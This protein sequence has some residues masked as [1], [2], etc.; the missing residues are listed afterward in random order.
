MDRRRFVVSG[1]AA[2]LVAVG[3]PSVGEGATVSE[4]ARL[5]R[6]LRKAKSDL[7]KASDW[8]AWGHEA[9]LAVGAKEAPPPSPAS[10]A[11]FYQ[12]LLDQRAS[13]ENVAL[14]DFSENLPATAPV[15]TASLDSVRRDIRQRV[16]IVQTCVT[17]VQE[18][19]TT[20]DY[21]D[22]IL[23]ALEDQKER[24][25]QLGELVEGLYT[26]LN[27]HTPGF[28]TGLIQQFLFFKIFDLENSYIPT[29]AETA[30]I[31]KARR[32]KASAHINSRISM[33]LGS[34]NAIQQLLIIEKLGLQ[35][36]YERLEALDLDVTSLA[37]EVQVA[38][39]AES[40]ANRQLDL[41]KANQQAAQADLKNAEDSLADTE[42]RVR[43][44]SKQVENATN[45]YNE[46]YICPVSGST[47]D[48]CRVSGHQK[49]KE[50]YQNQRKWRKE[51]LDNLERDLSVYKKQTVN[52]R[53][54]VA[55]RR[56][57]L[58]SA[59]QDV[60]V[61]TDS[62]TRAK[63]AREAAV[64]KH[65]KRSEHVY[66]EKWRSR[67]DLHWAENGSDKATLDVA[68]A[69]LERM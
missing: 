36:E 60:S 12:M 50:E 6:T 44:T 34:A 25:R 63:A 23:R 31:A 4:W 3:M 29:V 30:G 14:P 18:A 11:E 27:T 53:G 67:A 55:G 17:E 2:A 22:L 37:D 24:L 47:W 38:R 43:T 1:G 69:Q 51:R 61:K 35:I 10:P 57:D 26:K 33:L 32:D 41:S 42:Q 7:D 40:E 62:L 9:T 59:E 58:R 8:I 20:V 19:R 28:I 49:Y 39:Q 65:A 52:A 46:P 64:Q 15:N 66:Q 45:V 56:Q 21:Y 54:T 13:I 68:V 16:M 48:G 5:L